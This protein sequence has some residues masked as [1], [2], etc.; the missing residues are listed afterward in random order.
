MVYWADVLYQNPAKEEDIHESVG[1]AV[2]TE[3]AD[4]I[5]S[6]EKAFRERTRSLSII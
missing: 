5:W 2:A 4:E 6:G 3:A 1:N